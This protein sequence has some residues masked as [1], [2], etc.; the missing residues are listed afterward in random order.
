[1]QI[2]D[3]DL[4]EA[5]HQHPE[6]QAVYQVIKES[7]LTVKVI[8]F[9]S[10]LFLEAVEQ[11]RIS[12]CL[13]SLVAWFFFF[14]CSD[15]SPCQHVFQQSKQT[16]INFQI[17]IFGRLLRIFYLFTKVSTENSKWVCLRYL[18]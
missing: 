6:L 10:A 18:C 9:Y 17:R 2:V 12:T 5:S 8:T 13:S 11:K 16:F 3:D 14:L 1:M 7:K 4:K 15:F